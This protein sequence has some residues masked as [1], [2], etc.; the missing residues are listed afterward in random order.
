MAVERPEDYFSRG[1]VI[2]ALWFSILAGPLIAAAQQ[3]AAFIL[4]PWACTTGLYPFLWL[5]T[6]TGVAV[7]LAAALVGYRLWKLAGEE[8]PTDEGGPISRTRF[9][10]MGGVL[11]SLFFTLFVITQGI[12]TLILS[13]CH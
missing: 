9:M 6:L 11:L 5:A 13:P 8:W 2:A 3:E 7:T 1:T 4:V 12:P 10:A